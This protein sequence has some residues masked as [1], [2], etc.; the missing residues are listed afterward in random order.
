MNFSNGRLLLQ[1][2]QLFHSSIR[3]RYA[4]FA[5]AISGKNVLNL[6]RMPTAIAFDMDG[7]LFDTV[8]ILVA[9]ET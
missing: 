5:F 3:F 6:P 1:S 8:A 2:R 7:L 4:L 9:E